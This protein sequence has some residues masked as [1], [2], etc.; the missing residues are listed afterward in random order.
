[1]GGR[2]KRGRIELSN[3]ERKGREKKEEKKGKRKEE[4]RT[5]ASFAN[6]SCTT[7][8]HTSKDPMSPPSIVTFLS[9]PV[10]PSLTLTTLRVPFARHGFPTTAFGFVL[11]NID[12][13]STNL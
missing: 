3:R 10:A 13:K 1:V 4:K 5:Y 7:R 12:M 6:T 9:T 8:S 2:K 11:Y